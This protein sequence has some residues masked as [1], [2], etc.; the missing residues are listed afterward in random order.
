MVMI[1]VDEHDGPLAI[2]T[3]QGVGGDQRVS[4]GILY[5]AGRKI[6]T[7]FSIFGLGPLLR[8]E[9]RG[10]ELRCGLADLVMF[11]GHEKVIRAPAIGAGGMGRRVRKVVIIMSGLAARGQES[12]KR[13]GQP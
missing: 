6:E 11:V 7:M 12:A 8:D 4:L 2:G 3:M 10:E 1:F 9:L 13:I 5:V